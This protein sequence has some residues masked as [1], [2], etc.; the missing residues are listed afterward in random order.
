MRSSL[1]GLMTQTPLNQSSRFLASLEL[2]RARDCRKVQRGE[3]ANR[4]PG[5]RRT[6]GLCYL[7]G[8]AASPHGTEGPLDWPSVQARQKAKPRKTSLLP[9]LEELTLKSSAMRRQVLPKQPLEHAPNNISLWSRFLGPMECCRSA[10]G[11]ATNTAARS[12][13]WLRWSTTHSKTTGMP[14]S[15][16]GPARE[17]RLRT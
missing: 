6:R 2:K 11:A 12:L 17:R 15:K 4:T 13:R 16:Q 8:S 10:C 9:L 14:S 5:K 3:E 7:S 1:L